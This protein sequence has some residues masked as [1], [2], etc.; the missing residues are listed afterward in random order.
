MARSSILGERGKSG[1]GGPRP[2]R[3][4]R[5][6]RPPKIK[7][8]ATGYET[9]ETAHF[10]ALLGFRP[11]TIQWC[12]PGLFAACTHSRQEKN[13]ISSNGAH[14]IGGAKRHSGILSWQHEV[15]RAS[16]PH[17]RTC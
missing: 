13:E 16:R 5:R 10:G 1:K 2:R 6:T 15:D 9:E 14:N 12:L 8:D 7:L 17:D 3:I 4:F 11:S